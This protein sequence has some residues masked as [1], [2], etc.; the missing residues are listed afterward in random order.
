MLVYHTVLVQV[1]EN[2]SRHWWLKRNRKCSPLIFCIS[3]ACREQWI[4]GLQEW[5]EVVG[6]TLKKLRLERLKDEIEHM[7]Y[8]E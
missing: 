3:F 2:F 5:Q 8:S 6:N 7:W 1:N 4:H